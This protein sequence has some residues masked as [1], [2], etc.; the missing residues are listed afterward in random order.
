MEGAA[1]ASRPWRWAHGDGRRR[2]PCPSLPLPPEAGPPSPSW[3]PDRPSPS[4][5]PQQAKRH[6]GLPG[7]VPQ[8]REA[9]A[10]PGVPGSPGTPPRTPTARGGPL[11]GEGQ[12]QPSLTP[13]TARQGVGPPGTRRAAWSGRTPQAPPEPLTC[14]IMSCSEMM[15]RAPCF[16][17]ICYAAL[18]DEH[19]ARL[20]PSDIAEGWRLSPVLWQTQ[21]QG[22]GR[23]CADGRGEPRGDPRICPA[24]VTCS[25]LPCVSAKAAA[26]GAQ[27]DPHSSLSS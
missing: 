7:P 22:L 14:E 17:V 3:A 9:P 25:L 26:A 21:G 27:A 19:P 5:G 15:F 10:S 18:G 12:G 2:R 8:R 11:E 16:G 24:L 23:L 13:T 6:P 1:G 4:F 20:S